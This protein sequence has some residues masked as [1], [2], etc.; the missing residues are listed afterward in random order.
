MEDQQII[1]L[2]NSRSD[3]AIVEIAAK[4]S[5]LCRSIVH[6]IL[7][8]DRDLE[9]VLNDIWLKIWNAIPPDAP[10]SLKA[11][12]S[13]IARNA[14]LDRYEYN[15]AEKRSSALTDAFEELE[16]CLSSPGPDSDRQLDSSAFR[17]LLN[18]FLR[19]QTEDNRR[20]FVRRYFY[21]QSVNE[22]AESMKV[23]ESKVKSSLFRTRNA[24]AAAMEKEGIAL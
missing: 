9:E 23:S 13:R 18:R 17:E 8:D 5:R 3:S 19:A 10:L 12:A 14:A 16:F 20:I 6:N 11:Y 4:Y 1:S 22:I 7:P 2:F 15:T 24:L 21:G